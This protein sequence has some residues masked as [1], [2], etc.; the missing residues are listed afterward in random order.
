MKEMDNN[1]LTKNYYKMR[2][3]SEIIGVPQSTLRYWEKEFTE[4][5]PR[6]NSTNQRSYSPSDLEILQ[7]IHYL[8][9]IKGMKIEAAR[10]QIRHNKKNISKKINVIEKLK[11]VRKELE[12]M[13]HSLNLREQKLMGKNREE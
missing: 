7:I 3:A 8:L 2:E 10:E 6:R 12:V 5:K 9:H 1:R 4:L 13:L 11:E